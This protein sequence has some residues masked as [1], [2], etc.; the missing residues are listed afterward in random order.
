LEE[1]NRLLSDIALA[2]GFYDQSRFTRSFKK[3]RGITPGEYR[4][5]HRS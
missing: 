5:K 4:R 2:V 3:A 1:T